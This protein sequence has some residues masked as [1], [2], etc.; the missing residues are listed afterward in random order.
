MSSIYLIIFALD[1]M[2]IGYVTGK[3]SRLCDRMGVH[4]VERRW[5]NSGA[6]QSM[7]IAATQAS[8]FLRPVARP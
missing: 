6:S 4:L 1:N 7:H 3:T 5:K 2:E 8:P